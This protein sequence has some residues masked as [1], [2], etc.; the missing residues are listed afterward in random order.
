MAHDFRSY[1]RGNKRRVLPNSRELVTKW[2]STNPP[3]RIP[4]HS[5][6]L[7]IDWTELPTNPAQAPDYI[8]GSAALR[9]PEKSR[10]RY[11]LYWPVRYGGLNERDYE[12]RNMLERDFFLILEDSIKNELGIS[13]KKDWAQYSCVFIIPDLYEKV[14]VGRVLDE[15]IRDFGFQRVC[16]QQ[17]SLSATFGAGFSA[18]CIVDM[19]A[20][21]T[22]ICCVEDGM[23]IEDSRVNL[24]YGGYDVTETLT[25]MMLFDH[26]NYSDF[27][28]M[29]RHDFLLAEELKEKYTTMTDENISVQL[30]DFHVRAY[31][32]ETRKYSFKIYDEGMLAPLVCQI[33]TSKYTKTANISVGLLPT[34]H[35]R[36]LEQAHRQAQADTEIRRPLQ[37][38]SK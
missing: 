19:G 11:R 26:F 23:C 18:A 30:Y 27:N 4:E 37:S 33:P 13:H 16:F 36:P 3:D 32:Q 17:E 22:S 12:S 29:R 25:K 38:A 31:G 34:C 20:Q 1:R 2:N 8:I 9:I 35:L 15:F 21:K 10:P 28:L 5:D 14:F 24:K 7:R 6:P